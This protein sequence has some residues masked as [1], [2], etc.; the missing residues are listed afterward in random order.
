MA[1]FVDSNVSQ[2]RV[3]TFARNGGIAYNPFTANLPGNLTVKRFLNRL[4]FDR[5]MVI[6]LCPHFFV[7]PCTSPPVMHT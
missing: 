1:C 2:G 3:A 6:R 4:R 7:P 5:I